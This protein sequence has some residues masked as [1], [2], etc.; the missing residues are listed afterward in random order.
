L[1]PRALPAA[2]LLVCAAGK[3]TPLWCGRSIQS[4]DAKGE[5]LRDLQPCFETGLNG[6]LKSGRTIGSQRSIR[7]PASTSGGSTRPRE[8]KFASSSIAQCVQFRRPFPIRPKKSGQLRSMPRVSHTAGLSQIESSSAP[9][10]CSSSAEE[11]ASNSSLE[12]TV[13]APRADARRATAIL[14]GGH[15]TVSLCAS[16]QFSR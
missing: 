5:E 1:T 12:R 6:N 2:P 3:A 7:P 11:S 16:A 4:L 15:S 9:L 10:G 13:R 14:H 8:R